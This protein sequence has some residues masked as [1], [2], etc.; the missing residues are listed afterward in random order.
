MLLSAAS[1]EDR[2]G[3]PAL[4]AGD[5]QRFHA[6]ILRTAQEPERC[7][8]PGRRRV[9]VAEG[10]CLL[11]SDGVGADGSPQVDKER[12]KTFVRFESICIISRR[13]PTKQICE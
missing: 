11:H 5:K 12:I 13:K 3:V 10:L 8:A 4:P 6:Q 2:R 9:A 1:V 7:E